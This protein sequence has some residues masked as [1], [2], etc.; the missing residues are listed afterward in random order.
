MYTLGNKLLWS[1]PSRYLP[2]I[3]AWLRPAAHHGELSQVTT[4]F[5]LWWR[6]LCLST[7]PVQQGCSINIFSL[8]IHSL[9][10]SSFWEN[11]HPPPHVTYHV[12]CVRCHKP[13]VTCQVSC[14]RCHITCHIFFVFTKCWSWLVEG[15]LSM[16]P[17]LSRFSS[18]CFYS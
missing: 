13:G 2:P 4:T 5:L 6:E 8:F 3:A 7:D 9:I 14:L 12:S 1:T 16:G 17:T 10:E 18:Y 15:L 11:N